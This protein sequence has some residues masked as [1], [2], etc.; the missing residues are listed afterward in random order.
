[1][2]RGAGFQILHN[3][4]D[5][6]EIRYNA[7]KRRFMRGRFHIGEATL[8]IGHIGNFTIPKNPGFLINIFDKIQKKIDAKLL[9]VGDGPLKREIEEKAKEL[10]IEDKVIFTGVR[11]DVPDL[12]QAMD[13]FVFPSLTEGLPVTII[14]AQAA[15]LSCL[16]S[17]KVPIECKITDLV[18]QIPLSES[19]EA[20][21]NAAVEAAQI[22]RID[23]SK[24]IKAAGYD[25]TENAEKLQ[26]FYL[27]LAAGE[28]NVYLSELQHNM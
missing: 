20:W 23:T 2:F 17:D 26:N 14:E 28:K 18:Q 24:L 1:M 12:L 5:T 15:G 16:I 13:V 10:G 6:S 27:K 4:V 25:I 11:S 8:L 19:A 22:E 9:L 3:G 7:E 21:A